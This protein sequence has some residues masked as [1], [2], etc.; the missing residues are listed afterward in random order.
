MAP[1]K[2]Y[3]AK[4]DLAKARNRMDKG[5]RAQ[6][7]VKNRDKATA[8]AVHKGSPQQQQ[9][10]MEKKATRQQQREQHEQAHASLADRAQVKD[11]RQK[12]AFLKEAKANINKQHRQAEA[13]K[14]SLKT[15]SGESVQASPEQ[16]A[17]AAARKRTGKFQAGPH[18]GE[19]TPAAV[20]QAARSRVNDQLAKARA[21]L[22]GSARK[23]DVLHQGGGKRRLRGPDVLIN[24]TPGKRPK[25]L[26]PGQTIYTPEGPKVVGPRP[27]GR[28]PRVQPKRIDG[29]K[30]QRLKLRRRRR[31]RVQ[32]SLY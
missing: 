23:P 22:A 13:A 18:E 28:R 12:I 21:Q 31:P 25:P 3:A 1:R 24:N 7:V 17:R 5:L 27:P 15:A 30:P 9:A 32:N 20:R 19:A 26:K 2:K 6:A 8:D 11:A 14:P 16:Q 4:P 29:P 10:T